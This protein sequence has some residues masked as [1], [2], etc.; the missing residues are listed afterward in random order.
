M[1]CLVSLDCRGWIPM[2]WV[3]HDGFTLRSDTFTDS[4]ANLGEYDGDYDEDGEVVISVEGVE[5]S[6]E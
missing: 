1:L 5:T 2:K 4:N 3:V 6:I